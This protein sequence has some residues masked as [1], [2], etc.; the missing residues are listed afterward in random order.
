MEV[1]KYGR[2][3]GQALG[4]EEERVGGWREEMSGR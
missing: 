4:E 3:G 1:E 2:C